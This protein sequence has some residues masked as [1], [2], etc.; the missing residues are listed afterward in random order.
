[1]IQAATMGE[2]INHRMDYL[3]LVFVSFSRSALFNWLTW[4]V[5]FL[6]LSLAFFENPA[7]FRFVPFMSPSEGL[8][9]NGLFIEPWMPVVIEILCL[10]FYSVELAME[11]MYLG[12]ERFLGSKWR[13]FSVVLI[14]FM[15]VDSL[16]DLAISHVR[17]TR[18]F[19]PFFIASHSLLQKR[20]LNNIRKTVPKI[21]D[22]LFFLGLHVFFFTLLGLLLFQGTEEGTIYFFGFINGFNSLF[23]LITTAN[24]PDVMMPAYR[25]NRLFFLFFF[26]FIVIGL[27]F[28]MSL[29]LAVVY[30]HYRHFLKVDVQR[31]YIRQRANIMAA[32]SVLS[33]GDR[34][35]VT[36]AQYE[37]LM[38]SLK[39][40]WEND[41]TNVVF[42]YLDTERDGVLSM[43]NFCA[44]NDVLRWKF[45]R[46]THENSHAILYGFFNSPIW[47]EMKNLI[48]RRSVEFVV[49]LVIILNALLLTLQLELSFL[50]TEQ[51]DSIGLPP[52][53]SG[54]EDAFPWFFFNVVFT[55]LYTAETLIK[56]CILG[57]KP[58]WR[59]V[60]NRLDFVIVFSSLL[61]TIVLNLTDL[62][63]GD[64]GAQPIIRVVLLLRVLR[65]IRLISSI[66]RFKVIVSTIIQLIPTLT[67]LYGG[68][69]VMLYYIYAII[70][71]ELFQ[72]VTY[73]GNRDLVDSDY[74]NFDY[75][76]NNFNN[77]YSALVTLFELMVVNN[78]FVTMDGYVR[79][80]DWGYFF[81]FT[82]I[83]FYMFYIMSVVIMINLV[84]AFIL[85]AFILQWE[86][87]KASW[88][89]E[90]ASGVLE[91]YLQKLRGEGTII[92]T[93]TEVRTQA[94]DFDVV[95]SMNV[96]ET[97]F[98]MF[99]TELQMPSGREV[100]NVMSESDLDPQMPE[101][102]E[103]LEYHGIA[104]GTLGP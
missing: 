94:E 5:I 61:G 36:K 71:I 7:T 55:A 99:E 64:S 43:Q 56:I 26:A 78:W 84:V 54:D 70:G 96:Y 81:H 33:F 17:L 1:M 11:F 23:I 59:N 15:S 69:L 88:G 63:G 92:R 103:H 20:N 30:N 87:N 57:F 32:F 44:L 28:L 46:K 79:A 3:S 27:Y 101:L 100:F 74:D 66:P 67:V 93:S 91:S 24:Y 80:T 62:I 104:S 86:K 53:I 77:F 65:L 31:A 58:Y 38:H 72:G 19:R 35:F 10:L 8:V 14:W 2:K 75:Y 40:H 13:S 45:H 102:K 22:V 41:I 82:R 51:R 47:V 52:W 16:S 98:D 21:L 9:I 29:V 12:P 39:P 83:Y 90:S 89:A 49:D 18:V 42:N 50:T 60:W 76:A 85:E 37:Q 4:L 25:Q 34:G 48:Q 6:H 68:S 95:K 73:R 97:L